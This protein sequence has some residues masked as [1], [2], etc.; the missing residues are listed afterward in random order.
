MRTFQTLKARSCK[1]H[2]PNLSL[3]IQ[4]QVSDGCEFVEIRIAG[5]PF[6][7]LD[8]GPL[9][10]LVLHLQLDL[11]YL[12]F[13]NRPLR[14]RRCVGIASDGIGMMCSESL[15][16]PTTLGLVGACLCGSN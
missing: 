2:L 7:D 12:R 1:I 15:L 6:L 10:F 14:L 16:R 13:G 5:E 11:G 3:P 4:G 8:P 9:Q